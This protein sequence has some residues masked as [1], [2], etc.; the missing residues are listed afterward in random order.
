M[1]I[2][3]SSE[4]EDQYVSKAYSSIASNFNFKRTVAWT[5]TIDF[6]D[7]LQKGSIVLDAGCGNGRNMEI[8]KDLKMVG[9]DACP[10]LVEICKQKNLDVSVG[11]IRNIKIQDCTV[12][13]V[14]CVAVIGHI[15]NEIDRIRAVTELLRVTKNDGMILI[16]CWNTLAV[17]N[18]KRCGKFKKL[19]TDNDYIVTYGLENVERYYHLFDE[20]EL[21]NLLKKCDCDIHKIY[22]HPTGV[23]GIINKKSN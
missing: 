23:V 21:Y 12:D 4:I 9:F 16:Q 7:S 10:E 18:S 19:E 13:A 8:R 3:C 1:D 20:L 15:Y 14:I 17:L 2:I 5:P 11:D 6:L 22:D